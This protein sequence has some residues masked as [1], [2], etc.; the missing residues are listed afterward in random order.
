MLEG[1]EQAGHV[2]SRDLRGQPKPAGKGRT[3]QGEFEI[4]TAPLAGDII[5]AGYATPS[6]MVNMVDALPM[7]SIGA[8]LLR[9][10][11]VT[12]DMLGARLSLTR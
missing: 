2:R 9:D 8:A 11:A 12:F 7:I 4:R 10:Y 1:L 5:V 3:T 6:P